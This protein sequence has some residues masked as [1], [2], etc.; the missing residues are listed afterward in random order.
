MHLVYFPDAAAGLVAL[1]QM[2]YFIK[3]C[4][5]SLPF[6]MHLGFIRLNIVA[7]YLALQTFRLLRIYCVFLP[8][9]SFTVLLFGM[10]LVYLKHLILQQGWLP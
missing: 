9:F 10:H 2:T 3:L 8:R 5:G 6:C 4:P 7:V 1:A